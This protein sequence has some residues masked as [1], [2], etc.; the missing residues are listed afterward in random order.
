MPGFYQTNPGV[1]KSWEPDL[2]EIYQNTRALFNL[3][4]FL[5]RFTGNLE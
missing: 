5:V 4:S 1:N 3:P 2:E